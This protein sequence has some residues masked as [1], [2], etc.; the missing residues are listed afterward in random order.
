MEN[1]IHRMSSAIPTKQE[2]IV[3]L[4]V[5]LKGIP[6][7]DR[8]KL[9]NFKRHADAV[10]KTFSGTTSDY[11]YQLQET[12]FAPWVFGSNE[13]EYKKS[14]ELSKEVV[15]NILK[16][17]EDDPS[18]TLQSD[19]SQTFLPESLSPQSPIPAAEVKEQEEIISEKQNENSLQAPIESPIDI[20]KENFPL[21]ELQK[22]DT[23]QIADPA[24]KIGA[25]QEII[26]EGHPTPTDLHDSS[27]KKTIYNFFGKFFKVLQDFRVCPFAPWPACHESQGGH[28]NPSA[29]RKRV[30][31]VL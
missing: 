13:E 9:E 30:G 4:R 17:I 16:A 18:L 7:R 2:L 29:L 27:P 3:R 15:L 1:E 28:E 25:S 5:M 23:S 14:W 6:Y 22:N 20:P 10:I 31:R 19:S 12:R 26:S 11:R 24:I 21:E 8:E